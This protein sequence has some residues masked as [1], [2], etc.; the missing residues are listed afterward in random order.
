MV[1][2]SAIGDVVRTLPAVKGL[3]ERFPD[4][5]IAWLVE[6]KSSDILIGNPYLDKVIVFPRRDLVGGARSGRTRFLKKFVSDLR[7]E[8]LDTVLDF[9]GAFKSGLFSFLSGAQE[10]IGFQRH[11]TK[12]FNFLF[13]NHTVVPPGKRINRIERNISLVAALGASLLNLDVTMPVPA[14]TRMKVEKMLDPFDK[15]RPLVAIHPTTSRLFKHW[16]AENYAKVADKLLSDGAAQVMITYGPG[17]EEAAQKVVG[18]MRSNAAPLIP[19]RSLREYAWLVKQATVYFGSDTGPMH[20]A[21]AMG[22][23]VVALFGPTDP[24]VNG[25]YRQPHTILYKGLPC[26]PCKERRCS[27]NLECMTGITV[28]EAYAAVANMIHKISLRKT[29]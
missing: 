1:R 18:Y 29:V 13:I 23:P 11:H 10:R 19:T 15:R 21:S 28:E 17:E 26:S 24:V 14:E 27:R 3:R 9:H 20:I 6:D 4:A 7:A 16:D 2:L 12:E 5:Y 8:R 25:P 22:T